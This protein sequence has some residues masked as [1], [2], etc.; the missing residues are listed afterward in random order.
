[1]A[2]LHASCYALSR[3]LCARSLRFRIKVDEPE[4]SLDNRVYWRVTCYMFIDTKLGKKSVELKFNTVLYYRRLQQC[5][6]NNM[7]DK[8]FE[9]SYIDA[10]KVHLI[11]KH[12]LEVLK[13]FWLNRE[14][15]FRCTVCYNKKGQR[16]LKTLRANLL[17]IFTL[18]TFDLFGKVRQSINHSSLGIN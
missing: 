4:E 17:N 14:I 7:N 5:F 18:I 16:L 12:T 6:H 9:Q 15:K 13:K 10:R 3:K 2:D 8:R 1:M 11:R